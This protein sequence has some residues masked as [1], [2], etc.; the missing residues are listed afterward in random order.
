MN[1]NPQLVLDQ[2]NN[3]KHNNK[4]T[5]H[6]SHHKIKEEREEPEREKLSRDNS[7]LVSWEDLEGSSRN[8]SQL[9]SHTSLSSSRASRSGLSSP[10]IEPALS[11]ISKSTSKLNFHPQTTTIETITEA[12]GRL[13]GKKTNLQQQFTLL[14]SK[15]I[16]LGPCGA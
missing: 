3:N 1:P 4:S 16:L 6:H 9:P 12:A 8:H 7:S 10:A 5:D 14:R 2:H 13:Q 11:P 15:T